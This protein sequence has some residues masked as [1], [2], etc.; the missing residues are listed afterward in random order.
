MFCFC[1]EENDG[2]I[3]DSSK[4]LKI[5]KCG[6]LLSSGALI[7]VCEPFLLSILNNILLSLCMGTLLKG[8]PFVL[9]VSVFSCVHLEFLELCCSSFSVTIGLKRCLW[10]SLSQKKKK[11]S[12]SSK[13]LLFVLSHAFGYI[14]WIEKLFPHPFVNLCIWPQKSFPPTCQ[15]VVTQFLS[16]LFDSNA[17][18]FVFVFLNSLY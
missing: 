10:I 5:S 16:V 3:S 13:E 7:N 14:L 12:L 9:R 17:Y 4:S 8:G 2:F 18:S 11:T 15:H 1:C 6:E